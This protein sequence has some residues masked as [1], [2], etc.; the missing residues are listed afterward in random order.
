MNIDIIGY[1]RVSTLEQKLHLQTDAL[2]LAGCA[3]IFTDTLSGAKAIRPGLEE[4]K[5][6]LRPGDTVVVW[7]LDR[8]GRT[9]KDLIGLV[10]WFSDQGIGFRSLTEGFDTTTTGGTLV[11]QIFGAMAEFERNVTIERTKAGLAAAR[12]RGRFGGR[13]QVLDGPQR[14]LAVRMYHEKTYPLKVIC[15][16]YKISKTTLYNYVDLAEAEKPKGKK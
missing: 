7:R 3:R 6:F 10:G 13:P 12:A 9:L 1:A 16:M 2:E 15:K 14:A 11:F 8:L 5:L 4:L